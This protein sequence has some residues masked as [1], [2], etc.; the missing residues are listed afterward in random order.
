MFVHGYW[1]YNRIATLVVYIFYKTI[2]LRLAMFW[3]GFFSGFSGQQVCA[4]P[5]AFWTLVV[6]WRWLTGAFS[7]FPFH[8]IL[9]T[10]C[11]SSTTS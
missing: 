10:T 5:L 1:S 8:L 11:S 9:A 2:M 7:P 6:R 4:R 3:F